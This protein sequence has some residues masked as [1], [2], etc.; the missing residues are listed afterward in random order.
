MLTRLKNRVKCLFGKHFNVMQWTWTDFHTCEI[1]NKCLHC[2]YV[3]SK[4][5]TRRGKSYYDTF[6]SFWI[7]D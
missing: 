5:K 6:T 2:G 1:V 3:F 7:G 4:A